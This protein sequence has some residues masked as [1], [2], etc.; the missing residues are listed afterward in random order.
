VANP[1]SH[2]AGMIRLLYGFYVGRAIA[3]LRKFDGRVAKRLIDRH[4]INNLTINPAMLRILLDTL[5]PGEDLGRVRYVSS[6]TAPLTPALRE[7]FESRFGVPVLQSYGQT[8]LFGAIAIESVKDVLA[9]RRKPGSVGRPLPS[10]ELR[11]VTEDGTIAG[12]DVEG[13]IRVRSRAATHGYLGVADGNPYDVD[14]WLRTGDLGVRDSDGFLFITGRLKNVI[15][16]GGFN[17]VPEEVEAAL[18]ADPAVRDSVVVALPDDRLG[19]IPV[20]LVNSDCDADTVLANVRERLAPYKRPRRLYVVPEL[21][22]VLSGKIDRVRAQRML[23]SLVE[24]HG[25]SAR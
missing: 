2:T 9:G 1:L 19:E 5:E 7:E 11:I 8:E 6:G 24:E 18:A 3:L 10:V 17:I 15:I 22:K 21:P 4:R 23:D 16:C 20:A 14:G 25:G 12:P 13:E